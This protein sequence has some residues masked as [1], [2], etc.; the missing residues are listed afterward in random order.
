MEKKHHLRAHNHRMIS[1]MQILA[2]PW[3]SR[4]SSLAHLQELQACKGVSEGES[5]KSTYSADK[6]IMRYRPFKG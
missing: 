2:G 4:F 1:M 6:N 3:V 5:G